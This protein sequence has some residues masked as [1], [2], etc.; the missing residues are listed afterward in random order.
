M[1]KLIT[2]PKTKHKSGET[3]ANEKM[4]QETSVKVT[5]QVSQSA[6]KVAA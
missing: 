2:I 3:F 4:F 6:G 1:P 5:K